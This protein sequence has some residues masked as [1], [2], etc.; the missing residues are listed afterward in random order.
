MVKGTT[1]PAVSTSA[2]AADIQNFKSVIFDMHA[3]SQGGLSKIA[4]IARLALAALETPSNVRKDEDI[5]NALTAIWHLADDSENC[6]SCRAE[7]AGS[8]YVDGRLSR[9]R[10][11]NV[12][13]AA[14]KGA[15]A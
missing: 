1:I 15:P 6:I 4:S 9:R 5:A 7:D 11:A 14:D 12:Q 13:A 2:I 10:A 3:M 8:D